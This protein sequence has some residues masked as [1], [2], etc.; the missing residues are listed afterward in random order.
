[1]D[2]SETDITAF[3]ARTGALLSAAERIDAEL[4]L[5]L[6]HGFNVFDAIRPDENRLS[7]ILRDLLDPRGSHGQGQPFL[8]LFLGM[9]GDQRIEQL[10]DAN[11]PVD[12]YREHRTWS[13]EED[14]RRIDLV[15]L[16]H[17]PPDFAIA[18][19]NKP[20]T[21]EQDKQM[22]AY[23]EHLDR[24]YGDRFSLL[25]LSGCGNPPETLGPWDQRLKDAGRFHAL[26]YHE[27]ESNGRSKPS[28]HA[29]VM[30]CTHHAE[31]D[32]LRWFL[33]DFATWIA[34]NFQASESNEEIK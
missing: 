24:A 18:I 20:W 19:E 31:A 26:P 22:E 23:A 11:P 29:W 28:L 3:F 8:R 14:R 1:M 21:G 4:A 27:S 13:I 33:R 15:I 2:L 17:G 25:Y 32:K 30:D 5:H 6:G 12:V 16:I 34:E 7:D 10:L 9:L